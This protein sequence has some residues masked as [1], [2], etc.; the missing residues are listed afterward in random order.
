MNA[1]KAL[2]DATREFRVQAISEAREMSSQVVRAGWI[3]I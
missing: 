1:L 2:T 3:T